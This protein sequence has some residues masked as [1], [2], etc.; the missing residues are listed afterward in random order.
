[1]ARIAIPSVVSMFL[2]A[3]GL[4]AQ[5]MLGTL[6]NGPPV[7]MRLYLPAPYLVLAP[8]CGLLDAMSLLSLRQHLAT[9]VT[10]AVVFAAWRVVRASHQRRS[11]MPR[12]VSELRAAILLVLGI[13]AVYTVMTLVARPMAAI[14]LRNP[15]DLA[16]DFHSHT[17][18]SHDGNS[19]FGARASREWHRD[20]GFHAAYLSD[21]ATFAGFLAAAPENPAVAGNGTMLLR[22]IEVSCEGEHLV[23]IG[24]VL[25]PS[26]D[27][28]PRLVVDTGVVAILTIPGRLTSSHPRPPVRAI[29]VADG[30]PRA[31]DQMARDAG[32]IQT[33]ARLG[34]LAQVA[35]SNNHGWTRT[36]AAW[37]IVTIPGWRALDAAG[38]DA[39]IRARLARGASGGIRVA[40]RRRVAPPAG[41]LALAATVFAVGWLLARDLSIAERA[42]WIGWTWLLWL[43]WRMSARVRPNVGTAAARGTRC[44]SAHSAPGRLSRPRGSNARTRPSPPRPSA[45]P[46]RP[47]PHRSAP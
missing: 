22:A 27:C 8:F 11:V 19:S 12:V 46:S 24:P 17:N 7:E 45:R 2:L 21:H 31:I 6:G 37:S 23:L 40:E 18:A 28:D 26:G 9:I 44:S 25:N 36:A 10:A 20:A 34:A 16:V 3:A 42:S 33:I 43:A 13:A 47:A 4:F 14:E 1:M 29:E 39:A 5:P 32:R 30:A 38:L 41:S 35:S 15:D